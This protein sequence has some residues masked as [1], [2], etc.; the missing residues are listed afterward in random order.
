MC[1][2]IVIRWTLPPPG[3]GEYSVIRCIL[4]S[5]GPGKVRYNVHM[6]LI[7]N[8]KH[9]VNRTLEPYYLAIEPKTRGSR[10]IY[11][12]LLA[13]ANI[14]YLVD[15][16]WLYVQG[17]G[18]AC[19]G[20]TAPS[21]SVGDCQELNQVSFISAYTF[22]EGEVQVTINTYKSSHFFLL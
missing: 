17:R 7:N 15:I 13:K 1:V 20:E 2:P 6:K 18:G 19:L 3:S 22:S 10:M 4:P 14:I 5:E 9:S 11:Y 21:V 8:R 16:T 12:R